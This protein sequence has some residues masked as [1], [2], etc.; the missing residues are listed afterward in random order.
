MNASATNPD[1]LA[2]LVDA[3]CSTTATDGELSELDAILLTD[4]ASHTYYLDYCRLHVAL[5]LE[6]QTQSVVQKAFEHID[7][8]CALAVS[9]ASPCT[10]P[11]WA[12]PTPSLFG[13]LGNKI[14]ATIGFFSQELPFSLLIATV[15]TSLG[16]WGASLI[17][18]SGPEK[19]S[20][21]FSSLASEAT[22]DPTLEIVGKITGMVGCKWSREGRAPSGYDYV[23][24]GREYKLDSGLLEITY[25]T[26]SR[27]ILQGPVTYEVESRNGGFLALGKLT[28][29]IA[30]TKAK[31]FAVRTPTAVVTDLGTE[32]GVEVTKEGTT[33]SSVFRGSVKVQTASTEGKAEG[34]AQVLYE[35]QSVRVE[36]TGNK[37][38]T[39]RLTVLAEPIRSTHFVRK[40]PAMTIKL[41]D[42]VDVVAGGDGFSGRRDRGINPTTGQ[43]M[44]VPPPLTASGV[45]GDGKYHR[46]EGLSLIDGVFIPDGSR[47]PVQIDSSG[48]TFDSFGT[49]TSLTAGYIWAGGILPGEDQKKWFQVPAK[50]N[51]IDYSAPNHTVLGMHANKGITFNLEAIRRANPG[52]R[53]TGLRTL[54]GNTGAVSAEL[55]ILVDGQVRFRRRDV[56][57]SNGAFPAIIPLADSERFLTLAATDGGKGI[58]CC[59]TMFGDPQLELSRRHSYQEQRNN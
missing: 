54:A 24:M 47:G 57:A 58:P 34:I 22:Y 6:F 53:I 52:W 42:L 18:V 27:V 26:G 20:Q 55:W 9:S 32:F 36:K 44:N 37:N 16:L 33:T 56:A 19:T 29:E 15:L 11:T 5:E 59:W 4:E 49:T 50:L 40:I 46:V 31:G 48:H 23:L 38:D 7:P 45:V 3:V 25:D 51:G 2:Y 17:Y 30:T 21:N 1:R 39:Y 12:E 14:D 8:T 28:G 13:F 35:N 10:V 41:F 43:P